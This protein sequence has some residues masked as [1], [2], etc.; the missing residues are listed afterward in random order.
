MALAQSGRNT[1]CKKFLDETWVPARDE[2]THATIDYTRHIRT[3]LGTD[4]VF[5]NLG[6]QT[7]FLDRFTGELAEFHFSNAASFIFIVD[8]INIKNVPK[9]KYYF[10][11]SLKCLSKFSPEALVFVFIHKM[12]LIPRSMKEE[13]SSTIRSYLGAGIDR[14]IY[15]AET[16]IFDHTSINAIEAVYKANLHVFP[17][18]S[19]PS[20]PPHSE[21]SEDEYSLNSHYLKEALQQFRE[22]YL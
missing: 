15:W 2:A 20:Y 16:S 19:P 8:A 6:G 14:D 3:I 1:L 4:F 22:T 5:F 17:G 9:S 7:S 10:D 12:D 11:V 21:L 18:D 13:V